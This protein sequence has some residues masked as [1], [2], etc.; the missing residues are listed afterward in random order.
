MFIVYSGFMLA[1]FERCL[2][3]PSLNKLCIYQLLLL[4]LILSI[5]L[6]FLPPIIAISHEMHLECRE[7]T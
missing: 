7:Q 4:C 3:V 2:K 6:Q 5:T 1:V